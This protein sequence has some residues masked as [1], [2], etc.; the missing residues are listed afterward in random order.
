M[1][2]MC[3]CVFVDRFSVVE[4]NIISTDVGHICA[5]KFKIDWIIQA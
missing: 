3:E 4:T 1:T 5:G 2:S